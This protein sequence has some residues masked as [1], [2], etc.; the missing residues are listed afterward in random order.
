MNGASGDAHDDDDRAAR[1]RR[2]V[3]TLLQERA[4]GQGSHF[5]EVVRPGGHYQEGPVVE[6]MLGTTR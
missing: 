3:Y 2:V 5:V 4:D 1:W 6:D